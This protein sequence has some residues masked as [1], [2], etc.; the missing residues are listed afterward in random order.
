MWVHASSNGQHLVQNWYKIWYN[1]GT[2][3]YSPFCILILS[4]TVVKLQYRM[5]NN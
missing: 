5:D 2:T 3:L 4:I 1:N